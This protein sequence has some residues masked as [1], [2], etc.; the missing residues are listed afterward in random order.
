VTIDGNLSVNAATGPISLYIILDPTIYSSSTAALTI[1]VGS[2]VNAKASYNPGDTLPDASQLRIYSNSTGTFGN[3][4]GQAYYMGAIVYAPQASLTGDGCKSV[5]YGSLV[6]NTLTCNG[7]PH[8]TVHYDTDL[9]NIYGPWSIT[10]Y[11]QIP[12]G[13]VP[14]F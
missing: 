11:T 5:Y 3:V 12:P 10:G 7:G 1:T 4:N 6:I 13:S 2:T 14:S 9:A 8:L